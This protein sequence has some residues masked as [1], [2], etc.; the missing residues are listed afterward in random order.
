[1]SKRPASLTAHRNTLAKRHRK[2]MQSG[3]VQAARNQ[4]TQ[5]V[6]AWALVT[7]RANGTISAEWDTGSIMPMWAFPSTMEAALRRDMEDSGVEETWR[8][9]LSERPKT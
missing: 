6:R 8:P 9:E 2:N 7:V 3:M 1:M 4:G 5:D